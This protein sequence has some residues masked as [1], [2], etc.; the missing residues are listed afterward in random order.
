MAGTVN[1]FVALLAARHRLPG[2]AARHRR[3]LLIVIVV[4]TSCGAPGGGCATSRGICCTSTPTSGSGLALP[5][6]LWTG[7]DFLDSRRPRLLVGA[8]GR[9][10]GR[11]RWSSGSACRCTAAYVTTC[12]SPARPRKPRR[13]LGHHDAARLLDRLPARAGQFF[14]WRF[15]HGPGWSRAHPYSLSA[16]PDGTLRITVKDLGDGSAGVAYL[17]PGTRVM[18]EGPYGGCTRRPHPPGHPARVRHR[19]HPDAGPARGP[20]QRPGDVTLIYRARTSSR[21]GPTHRDRAARQPRGARVVFVLGRRIPG[22]VSWLPRVGG[23]PERRRGTAAAGA[24]HRR[25][26][27]LPVRRHRVDGRRRAGRP[28]VWRPGLRIHS[29]RFSW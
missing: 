4:L 19:H 1:V 5:H 12:G 20:A 8:V 6:Q 13:G 18:I 26:R 2:D 17:R 9:G 15:L 14:I 11:D 28:G 29:E 25:P 16:A 10:R 7:P 24:R 22:R 3:T 27:R 23:P 21:P